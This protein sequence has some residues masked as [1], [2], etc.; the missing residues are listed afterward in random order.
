MSAIWQDRQDKSSCHVC[1]SPSVVIAYLMQLR[2]WPLNDSYKWVHDRRP[3]ISV[4]E[5]MSG[6]CCQAANT[7]LQ[8]SAVLA[9]ALRPVMQ[10]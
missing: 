7:Y 5:G 3:I 9:T 1:R 10:I 4:Q 2:Q 6:V 8:R